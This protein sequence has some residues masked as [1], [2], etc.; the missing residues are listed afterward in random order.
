MNER[1]SMNGKPVFTVPAKTVINFK[2]A[3][4]EKLLCTGPTFSAGSACPYSCSFCYVPSQMN[5]QMPWLEAHGVAGKHEDI[6]IRRANAVEIAIAQILSRPE[7]E[8]FTKF[9]TP[10]TVVY[11]SPLTDVAANMDLVK[12]TV[13]L[14]LAILQNTNWDIRLLSKSNLLPKVA[15]MLSD[16]DD[17]CSTSDFARHGYAAR[18]IY[19]VSTGT[20][21]D[22]I[23]AAF[24]EGC[25]LV[26]KRI[27]SIRWLQ[28]HGYRTFAM[29]CPSLPM[30]DY[31]HFAKTM[32]DELQYDKM[33]HV[34]AEVINLRGESFTRTVAALRGAGF[35]PW[36]DDLVRVSKDKDA[37]EEY[38]R[39]TFLAHRKW[40]GG[41]LRFLQY[42]DE[43]NIGWW[44]HYA[45][46]GAVLLG[47]LVHNDA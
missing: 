10:P 44:S 47:K 4:K 16:A 24:E 46:S 42:V 37:W 14:C 3:F 33:E 5:K 25:P 18:V 27:Q 8:R 26:S 20:L 28:D 21:D 17:G 1:A 41:R 11:S 29:V 45:D 23:A 2:S 36:A 31:D 7:S 22:R 30:N 6:V 15:K 39:A 13:D 35:G 38:A 12:E 43:N 19:G 40:A 9:G 34:W 32:R